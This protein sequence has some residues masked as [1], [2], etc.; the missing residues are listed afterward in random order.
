MPQGT[1]RDFDAHTGAGSLLD[2]A[3]VEHRF[4]REA[5]T[6]SGLQELRIG[7]R[8]RYEFEGDA[9]EP[10]IAQLNIVSL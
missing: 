10:R 9:D 6:A 4:D 1:I 5:F 7:Q 2:D 3:L 8:V